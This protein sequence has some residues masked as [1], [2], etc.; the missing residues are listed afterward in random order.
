MN[1]DLVIER[2]IA[3]Y[4]QK[5]ASLIMKARD[6]RLGRMNMDVRG[7]LGAP[8]RSHNI[9]SVRIGKYCIDE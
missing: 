5:A 3:I 9:L 7:G 2:V 6:W 1:S 8:R 4:D